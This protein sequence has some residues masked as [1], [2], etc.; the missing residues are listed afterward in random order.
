ME[1]GFGEPFAAGLA[2]E[3]ALDLAGILTHC[4]PR[5]FLRLGPPTGI[6]SQPAVV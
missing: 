4:V 2:F 6:D 5:V 3:A 1:L